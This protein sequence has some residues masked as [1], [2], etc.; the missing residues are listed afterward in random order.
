MLHEGSFFSLLKVPQDW[1]R[2]ATSGG[3]GPMELILVA[4][5][6]WHQEVNAYQQGI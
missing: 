4:L 6:S 3:N 5:K 2:K 1:M